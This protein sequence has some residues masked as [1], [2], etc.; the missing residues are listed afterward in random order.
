MKLSE[1]TFLLYAAKSYNN[2]SC[3]STDDFLEDLNRIKY[4]KKLFYSYKEK[5]ILKERLIL[6][7]LIVLY[8][9]F[10]NRSCTSILF[11]KLKKYRECL[12]PFLLFLGMLP[13]TIYDV[14]KE[15]I[16]TYK[17]IKDQTIIDRLRQL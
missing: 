17:Y 1:D 3:T 16:Y 9:V 2:P 5:N 11:F 6:N 10:D 15:V 13:D 12:A 14:D 7:H 4:L 8:N